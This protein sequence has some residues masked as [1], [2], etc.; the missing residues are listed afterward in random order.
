MKTNHKYVINPRFQSWVIAIIIFLT[1]FYQPGTA[2]EEHPNWIAYDIGNV[3]SGGVTSL[4]SE[5]DTLWIG[6]DDRGLI[7]LNKITHEYTQYN[8]T[9][10]GF[11]YNSFYNILIDKSGDKLLLTADGLI[12]FDGFNF[13]V[14]DSL[15]SPYPHAPDQGMKF[16]KNGD[17]WVRRKPV[18]NGLLGDIA[19][20][21][22]K[23]WTVHS[24][25]DSLSPFFE[26]VLFNFDRLGNI[27]TW[28]FSKGL[29]EFDGS[30]WIFHKGIGDLF[31][32]ISGIEFGKDTNIVWITS[33]EPMS[34]RNQLVRYV[35]DTNYKIYNAWYKNSGFIHY[36]FDITIESD[37]S[38]W[39]TGDN[40]LTW[41]DGKETWAYY[42]FLR[43]LNDDR[44]GPMII[45]EYGNKW[46]AVGEY[47]W[48][49]STPPDYIVAFREGGVKLGVDEDPQVTQPRI[50]PNPARDYVY[51]NSS[52]IDDAG[53][54]WQ[55]QIYDILGN[56]V[57]S[58]A[59]ESDKININ[60]LSSG[61]YT[62]RFFNGGKQV[63]EK[64]MKE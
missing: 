42:T 25:T 60:Q 53:G 56:C 30:K 20:F 24:T 58:G 2:Q 29:N 22:G 63:V 36:Y 5:N 46:L 27:W 64:M 19:V 1:I 51:F 16:D 35:N 38:I 45:D 14:L 62:V 34:G 48:N 57:Q 39:I 44:T 11:K 12:K 50:Y 23:N 32:Y 13:T 49:Y 52:L 4:A 10:Y 47:E 37:S 17:L 28:I 8:L 55:Y 43:G 40:I 6:T 7:K 33:F 31:K 15:A 59:I 26:V 41:F 3:W 21:D 18:D 9:D 61:F 54:I